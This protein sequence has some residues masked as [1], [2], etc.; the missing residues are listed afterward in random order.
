M[1]TRLLIALL[2]AAAITVGLLLFMNEAVNRFVLR[3]PTE[4]FAITDFIRAP[5]RGRQL[6]EVQVVPES[7]PER[8]ELELEE[9]ELADEHEALTPTME[10]IAL[11]PEQPLI[12]EE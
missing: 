9:Q 5:D 7:A 4:Y 8:P 11:P 10:E 12:I 6:P 2:G 1:I 3:D